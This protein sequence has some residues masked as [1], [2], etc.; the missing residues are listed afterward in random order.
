MTWTTDW[1]NAVSEVISEIES[2]ANSVNPIV[3]A[4]NSNSLSSINS[5]D[6]EGKFL[7]LY[8]I[9]TVTDATSSIEIHIEVNGDTIANVMTDTSGRFVIDLTIYY[10]GSR[11]Y[12]NG[13]SVVSG[14][15]GDGIGSPSTFTFSLVAGSGDSTLSTAN[16]VLKYA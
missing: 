10:D 6:V 9:G 1:S 12:A 2:V 3:S 16:F 4:T 15:S 7:K 11:L 5:S 13:D 8:A 14:Q